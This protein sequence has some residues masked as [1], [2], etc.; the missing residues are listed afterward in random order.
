[1]FVSRGAYYLLV[2]TFKMAA[3]LLQWLY[4]PNLPGSTFPEDTTGSLSTVPI[5]KP[6][7]LV[8]QREGRLALTRGWILI[9]FSFFSLFKSIP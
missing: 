5:Y 4:S 8:V 1:M 3:K 9:P 2:E 7:L 6:D